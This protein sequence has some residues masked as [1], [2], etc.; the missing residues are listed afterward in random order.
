[1]G[2]R[3]F[4]R[5][6]AVVLLL[7][8][9]FALQ[10]RN[11]KAVCPQNMPPIC[12]KENGQVKG[13]IVD[14]Y[15]ELSERLKLPITVKSTPPKRTILEMKD[16]RAEMT[17][18]LYTKKR[19]EFSRYLS[20]PILTF[21]LILFGDKEYYFNY[22]GIND[23]DGKVIGVRR[24]YHYTDDYLKAA[25]EKRF[26]IV[27]ANSDPQLLALLEK[28]RVHY[29]LTPE[30]VVASSKERFA[31]KY[32]R[33]GYLD[34]ELRLMLAVS[35]KGALYGKFDDVENA[36]VGMAADGTLNKLRER[37]SSRLNL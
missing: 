33:Y 20:P 1:M 4:H 7:M 35:K 16:G 18:M 21:R 8:I 34:A 14:V 23:L 29:I 22:R 2:L 19:T 25:R 12:Y 36:I 17:T 24:G 32:V 37:Y 26:Q 5:V 6:G 11:I 28:G 30:F 31:G 27:E 3:T 10:A 15:F 13:L 9:P